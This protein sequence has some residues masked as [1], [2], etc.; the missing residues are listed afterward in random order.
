MEYLFGC[1]SFSNW[2]FYKKIRNSMT[3]AFKIAKINF[4][5]KLA[6]G[7]LDNILLEVCQINSKDEGKCGRFENLQKRY[8]CKDQ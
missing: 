1:Q 7:M 4:E 6:D 5:Y 3:N 8:L 2:N